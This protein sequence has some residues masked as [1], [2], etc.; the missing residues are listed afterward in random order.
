[1]TYAPL[2]VALLVALTACSSTST[3]SSNAPSD[4]APADGSDGE[5]D[6][7]T[8][9][10]GT[11]ANTPTG[12][13]SAGK[14]GADAFCQQLCDHAQQCASSYDASASTLASCMTSCQTSNEAANA[15]PPTELFRA[16][17]VAELGACI[18]AETCAQSLAETEAACASAIVY[19]NDAGLPVLEPTQAVALFCHDL[20]TSP[21]L[22]HDSGVEDCETAYM[23]Y[24]DDTLGGA[25]ACLSASGCSALASCYAAAF[26]Q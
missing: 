2:R 10:G 8:P 18:A 7:S 25:V 6:A 17:Y 23:F 11:G 12:A 16:D 24:S 15:N 14:A 13:E 20:E 1:M 9:D 26:T 4:A 22:E 5:R 19:G 3:P 21:C